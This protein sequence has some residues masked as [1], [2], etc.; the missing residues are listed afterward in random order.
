MI[1]AKQSSHALIEFL[2]SF[3]RVVHKFGHV[4]VGGSS[5]CFSF[6]RRGHVHVDGETKRDH[7]VDSRCERGRVVQGETGSEQCGFVEQDSQVLGGL[8]L[9]VV[10]NSPLE[11]LDDR[12]VRVDLERLSALHVIGHGRVSQSLGSHDSFHVGGP[13]ELTGDENT[14]GLGDSVRDDDLFDLLTQVLLDGLGQV[15]EFGNLLFTFGL[16]LVGLFELETFLGNTDELLALELLELSNGVFVDG[17]DKEQDFEALL[18]Q[19]LEEGRVLDGIEG[20]TGQVVDR[21][22]DF[23]HS[24]D[25]VLERGHFVDGLGRVESQEL[26]E[27]G[28][29]GGVLVDTELQVL[30]EGFVELGEVVLVLGDFRDQ[31]HS[32]LDNVLSDD[33]Q[34]LVLLQDFSGDVQRQVFRVDDTL[35]EV[36]VF[37]D[38]VLTVVH[39]EDSSD[40]ELDVVSLLLGL[41]QVEGSSLGDVQDGLEFKLTFNGE[42]LDSEVV[43]PVVG[44]RLVERSVLFVGDILGVSIDESWISI[45]K[46]VFRTSH[47]LPSP[48][49][50]GLVQFL[51]LDLG[52][53]DLLGLLGL[54][55]ILDFF[56]LGRLVLVILDLLSLIGNLGLDFLG[57]DQLDR[58]RDEFRVLLDDFSDLLLLEVFEL[59]FLQEQLHGGTSAQRFTFSIRGNG[60]SSTGGRLP[61]VL[62][63]VVVL[64]GNLNTFGNEVGRVETDTE[65]TNHGDISSGRESLH[66]SL[67]TGLGDRTQ[68]VD[69]VGLGHTD[70]SVSDGQGLVDLVGDDSDVEVLFG[71]EGRR[72]GQRLVSDLVQ[73]IGRVGLVGGRVSAVL[74]GRKDAITHDQFSQ[75]DFLVGVEGVDDQVQQLGDFGLEAVREELK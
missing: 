55:I 41:E 15:F 39:D 40:V 16:L 73:G 75:E 44:E 62:F 24:G 25:V 10:G 8:V 22:L 70:T 4:S 34:D 72:V 47:H 52:L 60:E 43:F 21:L 45:P 9:L 29:V 38:Q 48:Q 31:V 17:V 28:S 18:L 6:R 46:G 61:N 59:V 58:V 69:Q 11:L 42:V 50:L 53:L 49:R 13:A 19:D 27:L 5:G 2:H 71:V 3:G 56:N 26:G 51:V 35:D 23:G 65:L 32:L 1:Y 36:E 66:K 54:V 64:G 33:L 74:E 68:V 37:G 57:N 63:V 30:T 7:S 14:G 20:F 67:G 12:V